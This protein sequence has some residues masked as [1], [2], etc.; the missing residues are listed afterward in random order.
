ME[1]FWLKRH[2]THS[3]SI[4]F[5]NK[6]D[7]QIKHG[8]NRYVF[9]FAFNYLQ[10]ELHRLKVTYSHLYAKMFFLLNNFEPQM[11]FAHLFR[12]RHEI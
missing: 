6:S 2:A 1:F 3:I 11:L 4:T 9:F 12:S 5:K 10:H 8:Q 7:Y